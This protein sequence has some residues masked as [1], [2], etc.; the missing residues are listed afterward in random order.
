M[1]MDNWITAGIGFIGG[2]FVGA[3]YT[4]WRTDRRNRIQSIHHKILVSTIDLP[5]II[6]QD[7]GALISLKR[8]MQERSEPVLFKELAIVQ[9]ELINTGNKDYESFEFAFN[10]PENSKVIGLQNEGKGRLHNVT[11]KPEIT[12]NEPTHQIDFTLH[13]FNRKERYKITM[14]VN[15]TDKD[16]ANNIKLDTRQSIKFIDVDS[17]KKLT[18]NLTGL[19]LLLTLT[20]GCGYLVMNYDFKYN[21]ST[22]ILIVMGALFGTF[23][24]EIIKWK[25]R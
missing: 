23:M 1:T 3:I 18:L 15:G 24:G 2:G 8:H 4:N 17:D 12:M 9:I 20:I 7:Y 21:L 5:Q 25:S 16:L 10:I 11:H 13:P 14:V 19:V 6:M 22:Y